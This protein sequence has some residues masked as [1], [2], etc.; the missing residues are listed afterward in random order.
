MDSNIEWCAFLFVDQCN[1][2]VLVKANLRV[3]VEDGL[4]GVGVPALSIT[5]VTYG[6]EDMIRIVLRAQSWL[7]GAG[8][9][10]TPAGT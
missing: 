2:H 5:H 1:I 3:V 9:G 10:D 7:G 8:D 4:V 6:D